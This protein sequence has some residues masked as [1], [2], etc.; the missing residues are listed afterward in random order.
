[1]L[2]SIAGYGFVR[3]FHPPQPF[4]WTRLTYDLVMLMIIFM[5][6]IWNAIEHHKFIVLPQFA[7]IIAAIIDTISV[8]A[9][10]FK[11]IGLEGSDGVT[12]S[13]WDALYFSMSTWTTLG[14]GDLYPLPAGRFIAAT[15]AIFGY[16]YLALLIALIMFHVQRFASSGKDGGV[17]STHLTK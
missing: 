7:K 10:A 2:A 5:T 9:A 11:D 14:Y 12:H 3:L 16:F 8:F 4:V 13:P 1:M 17:R 15:E 6:S